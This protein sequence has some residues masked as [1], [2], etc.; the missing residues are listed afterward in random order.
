MP[1]LL[2][3]IENVDRAICRHLDS[4]EGSERGV[5]S[6][7]II[8]CLISFVEHIM[9]RFYS[10]NA[11]IAV[12][13]EN[14]EQ[15]AEYA[16]VTSEFKELYRFH[17]YLKIV[18]IHYF[19]DEDNS[20]R[21]MLKYYKYLLDVKN[22]VEQY[23]GIEI[24]HNLDKFPLKT[25]TALEEYHR[26]IAEKIEMRPVSFTAKSDKY[27]VQKLKEIIVGRKTYYEVTFTPALSSTNK[28]HRVIAFTKLPVM[29]N[30]ACMFNLQE[31]TIEI[32]GRTMPITLIVGWQVAIR[33]CEYKHLSYILTGN[34][35]KPPF[36]EQLQICRF[37]TQ[38]QQTLTEIIDFPEKAYQRLVT[39]WRSKLD[40]TYFIDLLDKCRVIIKNEQP[41]QNLLRYLLFNMNNDII[42]DQ[43]GSDPNYKLSNLYFDFK[44]VPFDTMPFIS[45]PR[46]HNLHLASIFACIPSDNREHEILARKIKNNS[47]I[48]GH[49]FSTIDELVGYSDLYTLRDIYNNTLYYKHRAL[50]K[51]V[52]E[53]GQIYLNEYKEDTCT[54]IKK[55]F[56]MS[57]SGLEGY[58]EDISDFIDIGL[59]DV[60]CEEK[61]DILLKL[62]AESR[63]AMLY[64]S[65][66][67]GKTKL[68]EHIS[69]YFTNKQILY[70]TQ[71][72]SAKNNLEMRIKGENKMFSTVAGFT[73]ESS[74]IRPKCD[75]LVIDESSTISNKD[76]VKVLNKV[77]CECMLL[78]GDTYQISSIRFGNWFSA[79]KYF[80][81]K[82]SV[83]ELLTPFRAKDNTE[84]LEL[85][86]KVR[87]MDD[88][89]Q[90]K[91]S[92]QSCSLKVDESLLT[93]VNKDEVIL[94]LNYDGLYGINNINRFLQES[95]PNPAILWGIQYY[96]VGDP[97]I[98]WDASRFMG[99]LYNNMKGTI[100]NIEIFHAD[101]ADA[102]IQF[103]IELEEEIDEDMLSWCR[104]LRVVGKSDNGYPIVQFSVF[105]TESYDEDDSNVASMTIVPFQVAYA[106]SIHKSQGLEYDTVKVVITDEVDEMVTHNIFYTAITR[107]KKNLKIYWTPEVEVKVMSRIQPR[108]IS[109][110]VE[111]LSSYIQI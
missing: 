38:S 64:G 19:L 49:I 55:L 63:V 37:I 50:G 73:S 8:R 82:Q 39:E 104:D 52:I 2:E 32:L 46:R 5:I 43:C 65:A 20:E 10:H 44:S 42:K 14:I 97:I 34:R 79:A 72:N 89:V 100:A 3:K 93:E 98:F 40:K 47:E 83:F 59:I 75:L 28:S 77:E 105:K 81:P 60:D 51:L 26:K 70:L 107:A 30:Y 27:Y 94:C 4:I 17:K 36:K 25:D 69:D 12:T 48:Q 103:D 21:L 76:M 56:E 71:T 24:L 74:F 31:T 80:L 111:L 7:D 92:L 54:V 11:E 62:F 23:W 87:N 109:R 95:N 88:D 29:S 41:G 13:P 110:D 96:K 45:S 1:T 61:K 18:S 6:Q 108:D 68:I 67:V 53:N 33:E 106:V 66:G 85:W 58:T 78:V 35:Y 22:L 16:Q 90:E 86:A 91:M 57:S 9:L 15:A 99:V 84:L 102:R 101:T